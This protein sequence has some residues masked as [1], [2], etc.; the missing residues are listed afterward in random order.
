MAQTHEM[1]DSSWDEWFL[2]RNTHSHKEMP[3]IVT[4]KETKKPKSMLEGVNMALKSQH[5]K[6]PIV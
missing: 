4:S 3:E 2:T 1:N 6:N 5:V